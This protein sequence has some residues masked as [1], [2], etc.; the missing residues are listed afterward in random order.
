MRG[1]HRG[2]RSETGGGGSWEREGRRA[3]TRAAKMAQGA[4]WRETPST[5]CGGG[6]DQVP[7][8]RENARQVKRLLQRLAVHQPARASAKTD[9]KDAKTENRLRQQATE[10]ATTSKNGHQQEKRESSQA[11]AKHGTEA[12]HGATHTVGLPSGTGTGE[13]SWSIASPQRV[14]RSSQE[15]R[16]PPVRVS[17]RHRSSAV[18]STIALTKLMLSCAG[19]SFGCAWH[20]PREK[21]RCRSHVCRQRFS[22]PR[23]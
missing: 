12:Q 18:R 17:N 7:D 20:A 11:A 23:V 9:S 6:W 3:E 21:R 16:Q 13:L 8:K 1:G 5:A 2:Q 4:R 19:F 22:R 15:Q 14:P 10:P